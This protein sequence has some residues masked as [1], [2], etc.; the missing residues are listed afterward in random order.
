MTETI[1]PLKVLQSIR[2]VTGGYEAQTL[3]TA[4]GSIFGAYLLFQQVLIAEMAAP[5]KRVLS[6]QTV[7]ANGGTSGQPC[8]I[9]VETLQSGRSFAFITLTFRQGDLVVSRAE[10]M[11]T[12][13][14]ADYLHHRNAGLPPEAVDTW[15]Q[16]PPGLWPGAAHRWP[17]SSI[18]Q[19]DVR[20]SLAEQPSP[21]VT[22]A[23]VALAS[24]PAVMASLMGFVDVKAA[25]PG[26]VP[27]NVLTQTIT[28]LEPADLVAGMVIRSAPRYAGQG[29]VHGDG[30]IMDVSG[31]LLATF[32]T[33]GVLREPR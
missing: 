18:E 15:A 13:D 14:E 16:T 29:R 25:S 11:L 19:L 2:T 22:R 5:G 26:R 6:I 4:H 31:N 24:E 10:V 17:G 33:T 32:D 28:L 20:F 1:D 27:G 12:T 7:F 3:P 21:S 30:T 9:S 8:Q 23:L